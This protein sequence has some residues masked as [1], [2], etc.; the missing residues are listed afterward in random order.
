MT[1][2]TYDYVVV[3]GGSA[4]TVVA[5]RLAEGGAH[6]L[7]LE[8]GKNDRRRL[9]ILIPAGVAVAYEKHNWKYPAEP[10]PS[11]GNRP[12]AW[13]AGKVMGGGGSINSCVYVRGNRADYDGWA[14]LGCK[15]WDYASVLPAFKRIETWEG[16]ENSFRGDSGPVSVITQCNRGQANMAFIKA[17][18]QA[19]YPET[20]DYNGEKQDGVALAQVNHRRGTRSSSSREYIKRIAPKD[21]LTVRTQAT[22][23]RVLLEGKIAVGVE[24]KHKGE[25]RQARARQE[26]VLSAGTMATPKLLML[27]GIGPSAHLREHRIDLVRNLPGVGSNLHEHAYLM[28][29]YHAKIHT[30]NKPRIGD[31]L[32]GLKDYV[33][34][35][36]G[37]LALTMVQVQ[38]MAK[39]DPSLPAP[40]VQLQFTPI[41]ITR[42]VDENGMFN[43]QPAKQEG[44]LASSTFTHTRYRGR[45]SLRSADP[46]EPPRIEM[47]LLGH[48]DDLRDTLRGL[49]LVQEVMEQPAMKE[50][51]AGRFAPESECRTDADWEAYARGNVVPSYH[52]V[53]S[54][55]MGID[56]DAVVDPELRVHGI[57]RLRVI[58]ASVMPKVTTGNTNAPSMMIGERGADFLL[59]RS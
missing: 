28:Q 17:A 7:L 10:D 19:G 5:S 11:R 1:D 57:D 45:V 29:R 37:V 13:M 50:I 58:D 25:V 16:G 2:E 49:R 39:T 38:V 53:G 55:K 20:A 41:A 46:T 27:S 40:D 35:G 3:G 9:E 8:A 12:E 44:F 14:E 43:V 18:K 4:G 21:R 15:G 33:L 54:C 22:V 32:G 42:N 47:Q 36:T 48:P 52:P 56:D 30:F 31:I 23:A 24:Y 51:T 26:V 6:V 34:H 59:G